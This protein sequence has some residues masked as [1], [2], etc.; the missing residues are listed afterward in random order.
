[1]VDRDNFL[2][3]TRQSPKHWTHLIVLY[4]I[5]TLTAHYA[6]PPLLAPFG[7]TSPRD[8]AYEMFG[9]CRTILHM[10]LDI[11]TIQAIQGGILIGFYGLANP[12]VVNAWVYA[13]I[14]VRMSQE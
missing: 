1:M 3:Q 5:L 10:H 6:P 7:I 11:P 14:A 9:R 8:L 2:T 4:G 12:R 13:G